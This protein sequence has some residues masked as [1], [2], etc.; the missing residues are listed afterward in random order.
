MSSRR[1]RENGDFLFYNITN[2]DT[3]LRLPNYL[4]TGADL[5]FKYRGMRNNSLSIELIM[6]EIKCRPIQIPSGI[7]INV[8]KPNSPNKM[9]ATSRRVKPK[10]R[11]QANSRPLSDKAI[12]A[13]L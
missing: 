13:V 10:T 3:S 11:K 8:I 1:G 6:P 5:L 9:V 7:D 4:K 12:L 2:S